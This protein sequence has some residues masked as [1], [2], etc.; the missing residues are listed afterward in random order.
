MRHQYRELVI[1]VLIPFGVFAVFSAVMIALIQRNIRLSTRMHGIVTGK[2][3]VPTHGS[4][5]ASG[6]GGGRA[7]VVPDSWVL[8]I[9]DDGRHGH[10]VVSE[11]DFERIQTGDE[12][13]GNLRIQ[14]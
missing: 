11:H 10:A 12:Y 6:S 13:P 8:D 5:E 3:Y 7:I 1:Y 14:E 4:L 2:R 9:D